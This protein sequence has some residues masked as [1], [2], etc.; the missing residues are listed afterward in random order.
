MLSKEEKTQGEEAGQRTGWENIKEVFGG[1][2]KPCDIWWLY[3]TAIERELIVE[4][5]FD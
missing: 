4:R 2:D 3:P 1:A 5:E